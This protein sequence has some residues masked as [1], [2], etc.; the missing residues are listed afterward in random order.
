MADDWPA[1]DRTESAPTRDCLAFVEPSGAMVLSGRRGQTLEVVRVR[2]D[3]SLDAG[4]GR[5]GS[6]RI[7]LPIDVGL[8]LR[9]AAVD[10]HGRILLAGFVGSPDGSPAKGQPKHSSFVVAR[11]LPDGRPDRGFGNRGWVFTRFPRPLEVTSTRA[12]LDPRGR[13]LVAGTVIKP[14]Q[15]DGA[16][17][18]SRYLLGP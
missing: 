5:G 6:A 3:G 11:L 13:L 12:T 18:V 17:A 1:S 4:Y 8:H 16:F 9:P 7:H 14:H 15:R 10:R 2:A